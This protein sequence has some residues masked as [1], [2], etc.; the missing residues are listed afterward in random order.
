MIHT[1]AHSSQWLLAAMAAPR[2]L[3]LS[4][5]PTS[6]PATSRLHGPWQARV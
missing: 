3:L 4:R 2:P 5:C 1:A 6:S